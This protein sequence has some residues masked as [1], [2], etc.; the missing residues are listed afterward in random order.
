VL[1]IDGTGAVQLMAGGI[2]VNGSQPSWGWNNAIVYVGSG[3]SLVK[4]DPAGKNYTP[5]GV[6]GTQ[7]AVS[8]SGNWV[9]Y[10]ANNMLNIVSISGVVFGHYS[11]EIECPLPEWDPTGQA[12]VCDQTA[13]G[14]SYILGKD[15]SLP[16]YQN[17]SIAVMDP[18]GSTLY[19]VLTENSGE[20]WLIQNLLH[21]PTTGLVGQELGMGEY[22]DWYAPG[23]LHPAEDAFVN[24]FNNIQD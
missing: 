15:A 24:Q 10:S 14:L 6:N 2:P 12:V 4:T 13:V 20:T 21:I 16:I 22:S 18:T 7:P 3:N 9:A 11:T 17:G 19:S 5:L 8:P 23:T 1:N